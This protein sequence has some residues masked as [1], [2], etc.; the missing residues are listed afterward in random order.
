ME[1]TI[2]GDIVRSQAV[3]KP[4][5]WLNPLKEL[6]QKVGEQP[7]DW[8]IY[9]GD[10]FQLYSAPEKLLRISILIKAIV[11]KLNFKELDVRI[12]MGIGKIDFRSSFVSESAGEAFVYSGQLLDQLKE[13][14]IH[15][16]IKS[17]WQNLD[18]ELNMMFKLALI[19]MN[20]WTANSAEVAE[21]L[22]KESGITQVEI[23]K[24]LGIAQSSVNDRIKR[25]HIYEIIELEQ[26]YRDRIQS[27]INPIIT[28]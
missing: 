24:K 15:L 26:Y 9:R 19:I 8:E 4:E 25:G 17:P 20:S 3:E 22:F 5:I 27:Q 18:N 11:K 7:A 28:Y 1:G 12:A 21:I 23:A 13:N 2:T 10:S 14:K 16:G 6:F